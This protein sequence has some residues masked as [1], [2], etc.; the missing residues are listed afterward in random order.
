MLLNIFVVCSFLFL[1]PLGHLTFYQFNSSAHG[2]LACFQFL[3]IVNEHSGTS[4][5]V[6][7][8]SHLC[9]VSTEM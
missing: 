3:V 4:L 8:C 1:T 5:C 2:H 6:D 7:K 9:L